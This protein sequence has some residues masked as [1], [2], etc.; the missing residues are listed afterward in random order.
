MVTLKDELNGL[1][2]DFVSLQNFLK[3]KITSIEFKIN[4]IENK[5]CVEYFASKNEVVSSSTIV[6]ELD[7]QTRNIVE[8]LMWESTLSQSALRVRELFKDSNAREKFLRCCLELVLEKDEQYRKMAGTLFGH[9]ISQNIINQTNLF[10]S[11]SPVL[12]V[13]ENSNN[14]NTK[15]WCNLTEIL[16]PM[17]MDSHIKLLQVQR[18]AQTILKQ[19]YY[20]EFLDHLCC[21][22]ESSRKHKFKPKSMEALTTPLAQSTTFVAPA[23]V[24]GAIACDKRD[25]SAEL[26]DECAG[27]LQNLY[28]VESM[29]KFKPCF[30]NL[31]LDDP[32]PPKYDIEGLVNNLAPNNVDEAV[33]Q[34]R[35]VEM[36]EL[37]TAIEELIDQGVQKEPEQRLL[38]GSVLASAVGAKVFDGK[39]VVIAACK[40]IFKVQRLIVNQ[41]TRVS[42]CAAFVDM[43]LPL[44]GE[45]HLKFGQLSAV[46]SMALPEETKTIFL[47]FMERALNEKGLSEATSTMQPSAVTVKL[48]KRMRKFMGKSA[49]A[50]RTDDEQEEIG[51]ALTISDSKAVAAAAAMVPRGRL[52]PMRSERRDLMRQYAAPAAAQSSALAA[53]PAKHKPDV[54]VE[55]QSE[56]E[57]FLNLKRQKLLKERIE[58]AGDKMDVK[59]DDLLNDPNKKLQDGDLGGDPQLRADVQKAEGEQAPTKQ[60]ENLPSSA[61]KEKMQEIIEHLM[62]TG[63]LEECVSTVKETFNE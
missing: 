38:I 61:I 47:W 58:N 10:N 16:L 2:A 42:T 8:E 29:S 63:N 27:D 25:F 13:I 45:H 23:T 48:M 44:F 43:L 37:K 17:I 30:D 18:K 56:H 60:P 1:K 31:P 41:N 7:N 35:L 4:D 3:E 53:P 34:L 51:D 19:E 33:K 59:I 36:A 57:K 50:P 9:L 39:L 12:L 32:R 52:S 28:D 62:E 49:A 24:G 55:D 11:L 22:V 46:A 14:Y 6:Q 5:M 26:A 21:A 54:G 20:R 40:S 15:M